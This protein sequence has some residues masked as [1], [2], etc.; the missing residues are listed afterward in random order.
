MCVCMYVC[1]CVCVCV[2]VFVC[3]GEVDSS[4]ESISAGFK[5]APY[6]GAAGVIPDTPVPYL[7]VYG[8]VSYSCM[9]P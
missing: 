7:L 2:C 6:P 3:T 1:V 5:P 8:A 4:M 9:R